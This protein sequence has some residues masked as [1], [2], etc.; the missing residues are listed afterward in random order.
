MKKQVVEVLALMPHASSS[1]GAG[2]VGSGLSSGGGAS[3]S[4]GGVAGS[5]G[6][7]G[8]SRGGKI[9]VRGFVLA[10]RKIKKG[11]IQISTDT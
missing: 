3:A 8:I 5:G 2:A 9:V 11:K 10:W 4:S 7:G 6:L 1:S